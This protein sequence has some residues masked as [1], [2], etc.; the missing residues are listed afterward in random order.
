MALFLEGLGKH[1]VQTL[2][3][4]RGQ[5]YAASRLGAA[6]AQLVYSSK[7]LSFTSKA[8]LLVQREMESGRSP[9]V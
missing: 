3:D 6:S 8:L 2:F 7:N 9:L 5:L 1:R 4:K